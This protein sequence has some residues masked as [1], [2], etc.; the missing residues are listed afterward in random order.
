LNLTN[1]NFTENKQEIF[2]EKQ[3]SYQMDFWQVLLSQHYVMK[4]VSDLQQVGGFRQILLLPPPI[5]LTA[6]I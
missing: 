2:S 4:I 5:K 6:T 3:N 1:I